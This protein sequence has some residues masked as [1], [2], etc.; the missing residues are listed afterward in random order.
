MSRGVHTERAFEDAIQAHL[1][2]LGG[3][4]PGEPRDWDPARGLF[5]GHLLEYVRATQA[6]LWAELQREHGASVD[7]VVL[8]ALGRE[9][10]RRGVLGVLRRG[11]KVHGKRIGCATFA[12]ASGLNPELAAA[13]RANQVIVTRQVHCL[14]D[15]HQSVDMLLSL[16]GFPVA[17]L[18]L[19]NPL[20]QQDVAHGM[21]QVRRR[22]HRAPFFDWAGGGALVHLVVDP[23]SVR[24]TTHVQGP[25][26]RFLPFDRGRE[27]GAGN[28]DVTSGYRTSY[29]WESVLRRDSFL[30]IV[31][32]F[33]FVRRGEVDEKTGKRAPDQLVFPRFHQLDAV[34]ELSEAVRREGA[35]RNYLVQHSAG[36]GKSNSISRLAHRLMSLHDAR[37]Q[38]VFHSVVVVTDRRV[39]DRQLQGTIE[40]IDHKGGVVQCI[41]EDS[42]QLAEA[43][44]AGKPIIITTL[45]KFPFVAEKVG[46]LP[47]RRYA[48]IVDEAHGSQ[49][50]ETAKSLKAVLAAPSLEAAA[51]AEAEADPGDDM[52][53]ATCRTPPRQRRWSSSGEGVW[54]GSQS[55]FTS[56]R[57]ARPSKRASSSTCCGTT[58]PTSPTTGCSR[59]PR[60][61][62]TSRSARPPG[63]SPAS[64]P[65]TP[66]AWPRGPR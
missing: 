29:L 23:D 21:A 48:V 41:R 1:V 20:T 2:E 61:T 8:D 24:M 46:A 28:P 22:D 33:L 7:E 56:T 55:R 3:W 65:S 6:P 51:A 53:D 39:L 25:A 9:L 14:A 50:G 15:P 31:G 16:N 64:C 60:T 58:P 10:K 47:G 17:V 36:S 52:E 59:P 27:K 44:R 18:E 13:Y 34:R 12:P 5:P 43:L 63:S 32:R 4:D 35:G 54:A 62:P 49:S 45:Q 30:D 57:C 37:D 26:T 11:F 66:T 40:Q 42:S 19:K 38:K